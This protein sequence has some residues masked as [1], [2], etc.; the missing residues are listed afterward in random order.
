MVRLREIPRTAAFAWSPGPLS[1]LLATGTKAGAVDADFSNDTTLELWELNLDASEQGVELQ[2]VATINADSR[3]NDI[4]WGQPSEQHPKGIIAG[5]LDSGALVLWDAEKLRTGASDALIEQIDKHT[6]PVQAIQFNPFRPHILASAGAK[7]ELYVHDLDDQSKSFRLGK[8]GAN[9]DEY[10][11]LDWNKKVAHILATGSSGG[12]VTVW[13][14][15]QKKE[16]LTLNNYGRKPVSAVSWDPEV[17]TRLVTAIPTDQH[18]LVLVWDLRNSN[19]PE[20]TLQGHDQGVLSLSWCIQDNDILLSCGKDNR[21][22]AWNP[23]TGET[24]GE[25]PVVTNWTFQT[26]FNPSNPNLLATASFDGKI[27]I[28][29]LQN[30]GTAGDQS[31]GTAQALDGEDFF[32]KT[33]VEPQGAS[34]SLQKPPKWLQRRAGVSFGFGGKLVKF[35]VVDNKSKISISTF[36]VDS[37]IGAASEEFNKAL[38][39]GDLAALCESKIEKASTEEEKADWTVIETLISDNP[40]RKL[41]DY[42]GF[43]DTEQKEPVEKEEPIQTN[44]TNDEGASF[45]DQSEFDGNILSDLAASKGAKTNN[46]FQMYTGSESEADKKITR[47]LML[48][49][50][51]AALDVALKEDRISD[52]FMIAICGGEKSIAKTQAAYFKKRSDGPNYLRLLASVV[53]KNLWDVV[54]NADL[55]DWKEVMATICTFADQS[56]FPDLCEALGD[57]LEESIDGEA[58]SFRKDASFCY[59]AGSKLEKVVVNWAEELQESEAAGAE[60]SSNDNSFS[61]HARSLQDFIEKVTVFRQVTGFTDSEQKKDA[62]W[63]LGPLYAKYVEYADVASSHGQLSIAEKYL[64]LLPERYPTAD[65]ARNRVKQA[66]RK[67]AAP[68]AATTRQ[69]QVPAAQRQTRVVPTYQPLQPTQATPQ[70]TSPYAPTNPLAAQPPAPAYKQPPARNAYTPAGYQPPQASIP[71]PG[72]G[73][74]QPPQ[75]HPIAPPP[76]NFTSSPSVPPATTRNNIPNWNDTPD[77]GPPKPTSRR[78][79]P[80]LGGNAISSPFPNQQGLAGP[81]S[82]PPQPGVSPGYPPVSRPTPPPPPKGPPQGPPRIMSPSSVPLQGEPRP[83][84]SAANTYAPP[85]PSNAYTPPQPS[86]FAPPQQPSVPRGA[87]PYNPPP[88]AAPPSNRYAPAPGA[89]PAAPPGGMAPPPRQIAQQPSSYAPSPYAPAPPSQAAPH[90]SAPPQGFARPP[91]QGSAQG[92]PRA[93]PPLGGPPGGAATGPARPESRPGTATSQKAASKHPA[94]DRTHI[95][96]GSQP[97]YDILNADMQRV[98]AR[99]PAQYRQH[100]IDTERRLNIL[101]DHL[102]NEDLLKPDTIQ[103]MNELAGHLQAK[104]YEEA[105]ALFTDIMTNKTDEGSNWMTGVKRL[106]Q[107][108]K[109][110]PA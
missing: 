23:H 35:G 88:S 66:T 68:Q 92:P 84:S 63:K 89:Q 7:G 17:P 82:G 41:V 96:A 72:Y 91:P 32:S 47:A 49:N 83:S 94:G 51:D 76:R 13:D 98:K 57:R 19:A 103:E 100:V 25:F 59:L 39:K 37:D 5:A 55:K 77:F 52:A 2:P 24:L 58:G 97:I 36:A 21:T 64:D 62:D 38:E 93:G 78:G 79:T 105:M 86:G 22:I 10:T 29:T 45:F 48:G 101:F 74:Y 80:A 12:F 61:I 73:G 40:R 3:F 67:A 46:P 109:S 71:Q 26:R 90:A 106:I 28:Q 75:Q 14:V 102:N 8:A 70:T 4:A 110:T 6:G 60:D 16:N 31:K 95:P 104:N 56:E 30:T 54:Y 108:S 11:S 69:T 27:A 43:A 15:R 33:H 65:V 53:G 50:F 85:Q 87:S 99:A 107:F 18:P 42:L 20:K 44:G 81:P 34:F 9:P 1:P